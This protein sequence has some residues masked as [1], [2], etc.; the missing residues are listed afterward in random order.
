M[1]VLWQL[2]VYLTM[3][4]FSSFMALFHKAILVLRHTRA[5]KVKKLRPP[6]IALWNGPGMHVAMNNLTENIF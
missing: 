1:Q 5:F 2:L 6:K 3:G 4:T